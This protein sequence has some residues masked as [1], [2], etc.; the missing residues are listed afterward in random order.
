M[1]LM[2]IEENFNLIVQ[3][4]FFPSLLHYNVLKI[5][6]KW[7]IKWT[8]YTLYPFSIKNVSCTL[9]LQEPL[10]S[11]LGRSQC[12]VF[13]DKSAKLHTAI[14]NSLDKLL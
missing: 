3:K 7:T 14:Q 8:N 4:L 9:A 10:P 2:G 12:T 11:V 13:L 5:T 6:V 1:A